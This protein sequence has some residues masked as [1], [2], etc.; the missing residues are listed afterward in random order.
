LRSIVDVTRTASESFGYL[1]FAISDNV[2]AVSFTFA[3]AQAAGLIL[4]SLR[5]NDS[6]KK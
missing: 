1:K 4:F 6:V 3:I 2:F 5:S